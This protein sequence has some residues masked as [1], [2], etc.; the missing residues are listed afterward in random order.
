[1]VV[2][3]LG[4]ITHMSSDPSILARDVVFARPILVIG[5]RNFYFLPGIR[6]V[7]ID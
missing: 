1:M 7:L 2:L 6:F 3:S 5:Y 4:G